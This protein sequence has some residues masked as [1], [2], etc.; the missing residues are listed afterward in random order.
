MMYIISVVKI[1]KQKESLTVLETQPDSVR[2]VENM[3][4]K[5]YNLSKCFAK[6]ILII[7]INKDRKGNSENGRE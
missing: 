5:S 6:S 2:S 7:S 3:R 1:E 4:T